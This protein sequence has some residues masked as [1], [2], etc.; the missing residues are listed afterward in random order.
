MA[1]YTWD[2]NTILRSI[3]KVRKLIE[4]ETDEVELARLYHYYDEMNVVLYESFCRP[5]VDLPLYKRMPEMAGSYLAN[6][7]YYNLLNPLD[8]A[9]DRN[10]DLYDEVDALKH[11]I[12]DQIIK[13]SN[14]Y[15]L[16]GKAI[17]ICHDFY[18]DLDEELFEHFKRFY[19]MRFNHLRFTKPNSEGNS[20]YV[21]IQYY[22]YGTNESFI[23]VVGNNNPSMSTTL[24]HEASHAIDNS[25][26]PDNYLN[27]D[28]FYEVISLFVQL[29]SYYKKVGN[30]NELYYYYRMY[31]DVDLYADYARDAYF[32]D[33][34]MDEYVNNNYVVSPEYYEALREKYKY[35]KKKVNS[36]LASYN[37]RDFCYPIS[38][39]MAL[40]LFH[41]FRQD[42]RRGIENLKRFIRTT[43]RN[44]YIPLVLSSEF[45]DMVSEEV[46]FLL[47]EAKDGF[48]KYKK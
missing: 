27:K 48:S 22:L 32:Y 17:S 41:I 46:K 1:R 47:T 23:S 7:R 38:F 37:P 2:A 42:E 18:Q 5:Y 30:F 16:K 20:N 13:V 25:M 24:I 9:I 45:T 35:S 39:S 44:E 4:K 28:Y 8:D 14:T 19:E 34:L 21:G 6:Q 36:F 11:D 40:S 15:V 31:G 26:N 33:N 29:V 12:I 43:N 10:I 3:K